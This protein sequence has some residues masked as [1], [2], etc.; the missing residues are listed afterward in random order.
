MSNKSSSTLKPVSSAN[1]SEQGSGE[2][3]GMV[4]GLQ[5]QLHLQRSALDA[6]HSQARE[7]EMKLRQ[8][9]AAL[10]TAQ[11]MERKRIASE[12]H[13]SVGS[14]LNAMTFAVGGALA[15]TGKGD[16]QGTTGM[17][18]KIAQQLKT[19]LDDVRRIAMDLRPA[20]L[21]DLGIVGTLSWYFR[22]FAAVYPHI[23]LHAKVEVTEADIP[24]ALRTPI[25]RV[26]QEAL[27]N[28]IKHANATEVQVRLTRGPAGVVLRIKDNGRGFASAGVQSR[29]VQPGIGLTSMHDRVDFSGGD[30]QI[31]SSSGN[32]TLITAT[33]SLS[34]VEMDTEKR[35]VNRGGRHDESR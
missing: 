26:V 17:L 18:Q 10:I 7:T 31:E 9:S 5:R 4:R 1:D 23:T 34:V 13:D 19:V 21:D 20:I 6:V 28:M 8:T 30:F 11:E 16:S 24:V 2:L 3:Y 22:E 12:L 27:N 14:A 29:V 15:L 25:Y 35:R 32:G 33:W